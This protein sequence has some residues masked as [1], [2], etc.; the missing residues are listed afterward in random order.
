MA[1]PLGRQ[2][3]ALPDRVRLILA[4]RGLSLA[5][6][7]RAS[8]ALNPGD[9]LRHIPHNFSS[10]LRNRRFSPGLYQVLA[11]SILSNYR[12]VDWLGV[13]GFSLDDVLCFHASLPALRTIELDA[14]V[15]QPGA[16]IPWFYDLTP[17]DLSLPLVPLSRWLAPGPPR[18]F[19]SLSHRS[20]E[21]YRY[22]KIGSQDALAFPDLLP[23]SIVRVHNRRF[24]C[25]ERLPTGKSAARR[26]YLVEHSRGLTCSRLYRSPSKK[27]FLCPRHLPYAPVELK[28]GKE[29]AVLGVAD[30]EIRQ[31]GQIVK[32]MVPSRLGH[33]WTPAPLAESSRAAHVGDFIRR[34]RKRSGLSFREASERTRII[35]RKLE[36]A[37]YYCAPGSLSD[38]EAQKLSPRHVPK[39]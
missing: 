15:Y 1:H 36:D 37:R 38:Y 14:R 13:F 35:A 3:P 34:A 5:E 6:V 25:L 17:A 18:R 9:R 4:T 7:S 31:L 33:F 32:P 27:I 29:A 2:S 20:S 12:L 30:L 28:E 21:T 19:D 10:P 24:S 16:S 11:L 26:L 22:V 8:R 23:G 39:L